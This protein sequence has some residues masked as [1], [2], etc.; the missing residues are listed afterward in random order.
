[1]ILQNDCK[2]HW[3]NKMTFLTSGLYFFFILQAEQEELDV[4]LAKRAKKGKTV[5]EK[6]LEEKTTLH[7]TSYY[8]HVFVMFYSSVSHVLKAYIK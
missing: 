8:L 3:K 4:I 5:E 6:T 7:G 2:F 1:M